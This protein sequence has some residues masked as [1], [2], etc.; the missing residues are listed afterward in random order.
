[1][2]YQ[3]VFIIEQALGHITHGQN[4][5]RNVARDPGVQAHWGL[6]TWATGGPASKI[7]V[8]KNNWTLQ[9]GL[10]TR[11]FLADIQRQASLDVIFF[12]T[13][14]TA[15]LA[16]D[17]LRR[18]PSVV[19]LD[20]TPSQYDSLGYTYAHNRGPDWLERRKWR[21]N[22]DCFQRARH[23]VTWSDWAK[24]GLVDEYQVP[25]EKITVIPPGVNIEEWTPSSIG[26]TVNLSG[27]VDSST[28]NQ[29]VRILFVGGDLQRKGGNL[30]IKAFRSLR[31][32]VVDSE[33]HP[34]LELHLVTRND[35]P[36]EPGLF[37]YNHMQPNSPKLKQLYLD[38]QIFCLPTYG[39]CLPMVLSEAGA[40]GLPL[41]STRVAA[42][43]EIVRD[44]ETGFL[45][46]PGDL[47]ALT[48]ALS[49]LICDPSLRARL[50]AHASDL[51]RRDY[52]AE[53]NAARLLDLLKRTAG[54]DQKVVN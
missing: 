40:A 38:S 27:R 18:I 29:V 4:L 17:W 45:V 2:P 35:I 42:I 50:A 51:V 31:Q 32:Q 13:Q 47:S 12:H 14:V 9:A 20:A 28:Y 7:P 41:V 43:P 39:D 3:I 15:V 5:R 25:P 46:P 36:A 30:L 16:Q 19:S 11:R 53:K 48:A 10:Q 21:L 44:G 8:Y 37:V 6:P 22:R 1:M 54:Q 34:T 26:Q 49:R 33:G 23:L 24:Q 52:D